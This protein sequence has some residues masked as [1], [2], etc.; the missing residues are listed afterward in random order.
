MA[1]TAL[2]RSRFGNPFIE[3]SPGLPSAAAGQLEFFRTPAVEKIHRTRIE[4]M[5]ASYARRASALSHEQIARE[6]FVRTG[7][8]VALIQPELERLM[9]EGTVGRQE[10]AVKV[11]F[12]GSSW[13]SSALQE[14]TR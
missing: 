1:R 4:N 3:V 2:R 11:T 7:G 13:A 14:V 6:L 12:S 10:R 9:A 8:L 5:N